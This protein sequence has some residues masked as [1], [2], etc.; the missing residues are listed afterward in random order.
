MD[1][2]LGEEGGLLANTGVNF[3]YQ[4]GSGTAFTPSRVESDVFGRGWYSPIAS[5][6]S[7]YK[8]WT[9]T[10][11]MR[12]D[13]D[14]QFGAYSANVYLWVT[15]LTNRSNVD[16]VFVGT[17]DPA[18]DG[19]LSTQEGKV[20]ATGNPDVVDFY[21]AQLRDPRNWGEPRQVRFGVQFDL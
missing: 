16:E 18:S 17:G 21:N 11:D 14:V 15:N 6:N 5:I 10:L 19:Y 9:S 2:R 8:P 1:Y 3:L 20:W 4:F 7:A 13:R 12:I